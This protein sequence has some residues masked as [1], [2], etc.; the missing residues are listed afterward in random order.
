[1]Y[2]IVAG[3]MLLLLQFTYGGFLCQHKGNHIPQKSVLAQEQTRL[4][5]G[6]DDLV[7]LRLHATF[8]PSQTVRVDL[9]LQKRNI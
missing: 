1:M 8:D 6:F 2:H 7:A 3:I 4:G 9:S 5:Q